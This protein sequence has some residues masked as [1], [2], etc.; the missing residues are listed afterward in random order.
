MGKLDKSGRTTARSQLFR[1]A[2]SGDEQEVLRFLRD[3]VGIDSRDPHARAVLHLAAWRGHDALVKALIAKG[4]VINA[5]DKHGFT[6]LDLAARAEHKSTVALLKKHGAETATKWSLHGAIL[7]GDLKAARSL[8]AKGADVNAADSGRFPLTLALEASREAMVNAVLEYKPNIKVA[9]E[10]CQSPLVAAISAGWRLP[11]IERLVG[12]GADVNG[13]GQWGRTPLFEAASR[14]DRDILVFLLSHGADWRAAAGHSMTPLSVALNGENLEVARD[15]VL[16]GVEHD[17]VDVAAIGD[18][19]LVEQALKDGANVNEPGTRGERALCAAARRG[20]GNVVKILL[21][22][23]ADPNA[24]GDGGVPLYHACREPSL[25]ILGMLLDAGADPNGCGGGGS[26]GETPL[27]HLGYAAYNNERGVM[28]AV[29][30]LLRRGADP[31]ICDNDGVDAIGRMKFWHRHDLARLM[32]TH[33]AQLSEARVDI[34]I[35]LD[36]VGQRL[37]VDLEFVL[38]LVKEGRLEAI[39][40]K[41]NVVRVS[42]ASLRRYVNGL[43]KVGGS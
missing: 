10:A 5:V 42:E 39:E 30:L 43:K 37:S 13:L 24:E 2:K 21:E 1:A 35:T 9:E 31:K 15:L 20:H 3:G 28:E 33:V 29:Q 17:L 36:A 32:E 26:R 40:L 12:L 41:K 16:A 27:H 34:L 38:Q 8:L 4:A 22:N 19:V 25:W 6:A 11:M 18:S 23:G 14:G 7:R